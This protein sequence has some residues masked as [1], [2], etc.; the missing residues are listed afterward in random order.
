MTRAAKI[1]LA[2]AAVI[3]VVAP[4]VFS[5]GFAISLFCQMGILVIFALSYNMLLGHTGLLSFGH[6]VYY[7]IG[8]FFTVHALNMVQGA[9]V[10]AVTFMPL[11]GGLAGLTF[12]LIFG[13]ITTRR[14]GTT[15]AMISLGV[16][17]MVAACS[18]MF[19]V[20]FGGEAGIP[21]N[22]AAREPIAGL[23]YGPQI[24]MFYLIALW[25]CACVAGMFALTR[26]PLGRMANAVRDNPERAQFVGYDPQRVRFLMVALSG[27]FAG[28]AGGLAALNYEIVTAESLSSLT[29]G[30]VLLATYL[31]GIGFFFGPV[32]GA[33]AVTLM[34]T[35][36]ASLTK[37]W[38]FYFGLVFLATVLFVPGGIASVIATQKRLWDAGLMRSVAP[39]Y[40]RMAIPVAMVFVAV[41]LLIELAYRASDGRGASMAAWFGSAA[42]LA[43][44]TTTCRW[45][46]QRE[47][48]G[49]SRATALLAGDRAP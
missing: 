15:F 2:L 39:I 14:A 8:A 41:V 23:S 34:Q 7:G 36:L 31:G 44:G 38:P 40:A 5:S 16:G 35:V 6:A 45:L 3:V 29:S 9:P 27:F 28:I 49:W 10:I 20:F 32:A 21:G 30:L 4:L 12:G 33:V 37:A 17:E 48:E 22:R 26:T 19:P 24:Q 42:L 1:S 25:L 11:V 43:L 18:L 46:W 47:R 13:Y